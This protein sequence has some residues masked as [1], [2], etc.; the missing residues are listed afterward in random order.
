MDP[1]PPRAPRRALRIALAVAEAAV[2]VATLGALGLVCSVPSTARLADENPTSTAFIDLRRAEAEA[3][4]KPL[5]LEW[6]WRSLGTISRYLRAAVVYAE[7]YNFYR[8]DGIDWHALEHAVTA[9]WNRGQMAVGGSTIT[10]QLAKNLYLSPRRSLIRKLREALIAFSLED[11]LTKQRILEL[12]LNVVEWGD[13]VF[14]AE[15]AA[16]HWFHHSA[17]TLSPA[18]AVR[19]AI[20]L[21]NPRTRAPSVRDPDLTRKCV[22]LI[23]MLRM[24]GL[25]DSVQERAALDEVGAPG[26]RVLPDRSVPPPVAAPPDAPPTPS[27]EPAPTTPAPS[28]EPP[29]AGRDEAAPDR[30]PPA[31]PDRTPPPE[32]PPP[33]RNP[34]PGASPGPSPEPNAPAAPPAEPAEP[35]P[36]PPGEPPG[37]AR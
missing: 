10:Q 31:A 4:G 24:Q 16:R 5:A 26:E 28:R 6:Q 14:G 35:R 34:P 23:R 18:E 20:A 13:G 8:H 3:A 2:V 30:G 1:T 27:G 21:P 25:I 29:A 19:L 9:D 22:R 37:G 11:H 15:A 12:Y 36:T 7:D 17:Q 32:P 33:D